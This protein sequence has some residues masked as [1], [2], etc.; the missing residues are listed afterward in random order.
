M[1]NV[2]LRRVCASLLPWK[3]SAC[4]LEVPPARGRV[5]ARACVRAALLIQHATRMRYSVTS[6]VAPLAQL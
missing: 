4:A 2:I 5:H 3:S 1:Y 6:F